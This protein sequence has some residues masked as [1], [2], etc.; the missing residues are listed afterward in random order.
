[1]GN[2]DEDSQHKQSISS[3]MLNPGVKEMLL[4]DTKDPPSL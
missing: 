1:M 3:I 2:E 4:A